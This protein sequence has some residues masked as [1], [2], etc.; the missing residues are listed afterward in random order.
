[1]GSHQRAFILC[2]RLLHFSVSHRVVMP[3]AVLAYPRGK[4]LPFQII[5]LTFGHGGGGGGGKESYLVVWRG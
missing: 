4:L 1:M 2:I 3:S 5:I